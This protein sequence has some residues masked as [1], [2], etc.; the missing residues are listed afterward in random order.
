MGE[1]CPVFD[2]LFEFCQIYA[3]GTIGTS[4]LFLLPTYYTF[5]R[6]EAF[7]LRLPAVVFLV[8]AHFFS[9]LPYVA[10]AL[11]VWCRCCPPIE[12][13]LVWHSDKLG[14]WTAPCQKM[15]GVWILLRERLGARN[16]GVAE[17]SCPSFVHRYWYSSRGRRGRGL[18]PHRQ[19]N[20][21]VW[22]DLASLFVGNPSLGGFPD[23]SGGAN[24][25][26]NPVIVDRL[27]LDTVFCFSEQTSVRSKD[28]S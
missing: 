22:P 10:F 13:R 25:D 17:I 3:G 18:L 8:R 2:N 7:S 23:A 28:N 15:R 1:D 14:R 26:V 12:Q 27:L 19:V 9:L 21:M 5:A 11:C 20:D 16:L 4:V 24:G 6:H